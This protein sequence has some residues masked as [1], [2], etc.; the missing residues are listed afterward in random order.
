MT[1]NILY[2]HRIQSPFLGIRFSTPRAVLLHHRDHPTPQ[3]HQLAG[4]L[5]ATVPLLQRLLVL[6]SGTVDSVW[7]W[8][9]MI[10]QRVVVDHK[11]VFV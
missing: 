11:G 7:K 9:V 4:A 6:G 3:I 8:D 10:L 1:W 2:W 5:A